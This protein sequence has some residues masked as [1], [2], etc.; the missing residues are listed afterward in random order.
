MNDTKRPVKT[1]TLLSQRKD[2]PDAVKRT[3]R[4]GSHP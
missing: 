3:R 2:M 4:H 1:L